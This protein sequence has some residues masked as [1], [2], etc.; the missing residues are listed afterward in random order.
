MLM[1]D[2]KVECL[3]HQGQFEITEPGIVEEHLQ[4][5]ELNLG[6]KGTFEAK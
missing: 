5:Q 1:I 3:E 6:I 2:W 4:V